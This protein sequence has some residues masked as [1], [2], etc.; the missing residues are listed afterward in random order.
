MYLRN[1]ECEK[2]VVWFERLKFNLLS[3]LIVLIILIIFFLGINVFLKISD[4]LLRQNTINP[5][6]NDSYL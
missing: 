3:L 2:I 1:R 4:L 6:S 5:H